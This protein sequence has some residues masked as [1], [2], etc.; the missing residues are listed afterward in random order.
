M[1]SSEPKD[2]M[3][4]LPT[5]TTDGLDVWRTIKGK[6]GRR[7]EAGQVPVPEAD[8]GCHGWKRL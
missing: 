3:C 6:K 2:R 5:M 1:S 4:L 7:A 8:T